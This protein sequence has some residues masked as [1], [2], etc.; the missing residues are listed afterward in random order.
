MIDGRDLAVG[1]QGPPGETKVYF[2]SSPLEI[3]PTGHYPAMYLRERRLGWLGWITG[4]GSLA[5]PFFPPRI[6]VR[7]SQS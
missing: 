2:V 3:R 4:V 1:L 7:N 6:S 5:G